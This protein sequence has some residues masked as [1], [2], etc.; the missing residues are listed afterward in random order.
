MC[1]AG[2]V[3]PVKDV[4]KI[5]LGYPFSVVNDIDLDSAAR[6]RLYYLDG[7][8]IA[9]GIVYRITEQVIDDP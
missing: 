5:L 8:V 2:T 1:I 6:H 3:I 9:V 4:G 7:L